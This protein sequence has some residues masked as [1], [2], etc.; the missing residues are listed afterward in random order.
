MR[1][2]IL[3]NIA[4][5][6]LVDVSV[7]SHQYR[8]EWSSD[9]YTSPEEFWADYDGPETGKIVHSWVWGPD[10]P[11][12][13]EYFLEQDIKDRYPNHGFIQLSSR[14]GKKLNIDLVKRPPSTLYP[15]G[16]SFCRQLLPVAVAL[17][18]GENG[19]PVSEMREISVIIQSKY[20]YTRACQCYTELMM[21]MGFTVLNSLTRGDGAIGEICDEER[22]TDLTAVLRDDNTARLSPKIHQGLDALRLLQTANFISSTRKK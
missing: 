9:Y 16:E 14:D 7:C 17:F 2:I 3:S 8:A 13:P 20:S 12:T 6:C 22:P 4:I 11:Q 18:L 15:D 21:D 19:W 10:I 5:L 1:H